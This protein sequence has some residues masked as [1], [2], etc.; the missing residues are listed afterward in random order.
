[1]DTTAPIRPT[2]QRERRISLTAG[3][4]AA[5]AARRQVRAAVYAWD[6][7]VDPH[8]A[9]LLTSELVTNAITHGAGGTVLLVITCT[10]GHLRV[11]VH[12][13]SCS[14]PVPVDAPADVEAGRGL[15][16]IASL[17]ADWGYYPTHAGKAVYFTLAFHAD[18]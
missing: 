13:T 18:P 7:P 4:A 3:P 6:V 17:S 9:V 1:M 11:D 16:L 12:D 5:A 2:V 14:A 15:M 10:C 8:T